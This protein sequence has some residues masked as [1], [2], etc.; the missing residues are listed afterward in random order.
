MGS[1]DL[2]DDPLFLGH[3]RMAFFRGDVTIPIVASVRKPR[4]QRE[5]C[6]GRGLLEAFRNTHC[7]GHVRDRR[8]RRAADGGI[9]DATVA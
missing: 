1:H 9:V 5:E 7:E 2:L 6:V 8:R 4:P 3:T